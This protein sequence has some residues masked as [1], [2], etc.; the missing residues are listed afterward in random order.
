MKGG[1]MTFNSTMV[2]LKH[3][4]ALY[5]IASRR[6]FN[7]T[8]VQLK[9]FGELKKRIIEESFN[10]TMVQLKPSFGFYY[11]RGEGKSS[12][13]GSGCP[14]WRLTTGSRRSGET[15]HPEEP[16]PLPINVL[17]KPFKAI[18]VLG[19]EKVGEPPLKFEP[20]LYGNLLRGHVVYFEFS[21][22]KFV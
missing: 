2:Q 17:L 5:L 18:P 19:K 11:S 15:R 3:K 21:V 7:S 16:F 22:L 20:F 14:D 10:S 4:L 12:T 13:P 9:P 8:M 1:D 6:A